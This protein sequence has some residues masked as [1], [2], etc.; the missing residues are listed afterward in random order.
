MKELVLIRAPSTRYG[1]FGMLMEDNVPF[2]V[3]LERKWLDNEVGKSC[4]PSGMYKCVRFDS[5]TFADTFRVDEVPGRT[6]IL[7]HKGNIMDDT[8]GCII[9]GEQ[10][11][12]INGVP[13]VRSSGVAMDEFM[14]RLKLEDKFILYIMWAK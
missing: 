10:F 11:E 1:T 9:L 4:I 5:P 2:C 13:A 14:E 3:T 12:P 7:F 8:H 6:G